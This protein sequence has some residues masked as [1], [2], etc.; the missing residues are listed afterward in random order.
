MAATTLVDASGAYPKA[1]DEGIILGPRSNISTS[2]IPAQSYHDNGC[3]AQKLVY[4]QGPRHNFGG[5]DDFF[6][7]HSTIVCTCRRFPIDHL[8]MCFMG[9]LVAITCRY[10]IDLILERSSL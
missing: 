5:A 4:T 9:Q 8:V 10:A 3:R 7:R 6:S 2:S 1:E